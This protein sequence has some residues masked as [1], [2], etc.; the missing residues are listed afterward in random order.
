MKYKS[1]WATPPVRKRKKVAESPSDDF[2]RDAVKEIKEQAKPKSRNQ[3]FA[4][5]LAAELDDFPQEASCVMSSLRYEIM[6]LVN[7]RRREWSGQTF[8]GSDTPSTSTMSPS[9]GMIN[10]IQDDQS[11]LVFSQMTNMNPNPYAPS[12]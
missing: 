12:G 8:Q 9:P 11:Q 7:R 2:F 10:Y 1:I 3:L 6:D 4:D 5:N